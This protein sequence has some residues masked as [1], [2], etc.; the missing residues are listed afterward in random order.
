MAIFSIG[1]F[2]F[3][4]NDLPH[5]MVRRQIRPF[6]HLCHGLFSR[7]N[8]RQTIAPS[9][10]VKELIYLLKC[11]LKRNP[12]GFA[13]LLFR[14]FFFGSK[15]PYKGIN[16]FF[17]GGCYALF[18]I[19]MTVDSQGTDSPITLIPGIPLLDAAEWA[20]LT[21]PLLA[22]NTTGLPKSSTAIPV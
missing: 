19:G 2:S 4:R 16:H 22:S 3:S 6:E 7:R 15:R 17:H 12:R 20:S 10:A 5:N 9:L 18:N 21:K 11:S 13:C 14:G 1:G 8:N